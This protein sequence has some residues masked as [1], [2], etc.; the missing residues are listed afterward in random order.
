[1]IYFLFFQNLRIEGEMYSFKFD[2]IPIAQKPYRTYFSNN[3][4]IQRQITELLKYDIIRPSSS[5]YSSPA[6]LVNKISD[7]PNH[8]TRLCID[9]RKLNQKTVPEHTP[10]PLIEQIIDRLSQSKIYAILDVKNAYWHIPIDEKDRHK[11]S[12]VTQLGYYEWNRPPYGLKNA[13]SQFE[14]I[15]KSVFTKHNIHYA[16]NYFDDII[17]HSKTYEEHIKH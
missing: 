16:L 1:M 9:Y 15:M 11:S 12:F 13:P 10:I 3:G 6:L 2:N 7:A 5:P 8:P 14:R 17:I 4:E